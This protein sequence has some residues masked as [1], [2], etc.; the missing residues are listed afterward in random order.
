M[1]GLRTVTLAWLAVT[2]P[3]AS[4][5]PGLRAELAGYQA[6]LARVGDTTALR[7]RERALEPG[8]DSS[9]TGTIP[10]LH[11]GLTR[12]RL[13]QVGDGWSFGRATRDFSAAAAQRPAWPW[14]WYGRALAE[15]GR[16]EWLAA[17]P[18]NLG[19]RVGYGA[20]EEALRSARQALVAEPGFLP[21][22]TLLVDAA[23]VLR[24]TQAVRAEVRP[25]LAGA[26]AAGL[27]TPELVLALVRVAREELDDSLP[28]SVPLDILLRYLPATAE[29]GHALA[30]TGF[31]AGTPWADSLYYAAAAR[32]DASGVLA[33][34]EA[35]GA[36]ADD[37]ALA[38]FD[39]A[40]AEDRAGTLRQFWEARARRDLRDPAER[41]AEHYRRLAHATRHFALQ[42]NRRYYSPNNLYRSAQ[43]WYDDRGVVWIRFGAP[44]DR[45]IVPLFGLPPLETW[46]YRRADGDLLLHFQAG[47]Y[48]SGA[49]DF[50]G[51]IDDYRLVPT[52]FDAMYQRSTAWDLLLLSR[53]PLHPVYCRYPAWGP[54]GRAQLVAEE[55]R[56]VIGSTE[57]AV[58]GEGW[59]RRFAHGLQARMEAFAVGRRGE[60]TLVHLAYQVPVA[61]REG[62]PAGARLQSPVHLRVAVLGAD[63]AAVAWVDTTTIASLPPGRPGVLEA[64]GRA[65]FAVP[66]GR[67]RYRVELAV[68][69][70]TGQVFP[71]D[72][73]E[74]GDFDGARLALSDLVL[75]RPGIGAPWAPEAA[76][77]AYF[78]PRA[79]W[80]RG[81]TLALYHEVYGLAAGAPYLVRLTLRRGRRTALTAAWEGTASGPVT[82]LSRALSLAALRPGDYLLE[83]AVTAADGG[84]ATTR[85]RVTITE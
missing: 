78:T 63:G 11:R 40:P 59:E 57:V 50:G 64:F 25:A 80:A 39:A 24:D 2:A 1:G 22:L 58:S 60:R 55:Q 83:L 26:W 44:D 5:S 16:A 48:S 66:P 52:L 9:D 69:D 56:V 19:S 43:Q 70:S 12:I 53:C 73:L 62:V 29:A 75:G 71:T 23:V 14:P 49:L 67:W 74:V 30:W 65:A 6:D 3:L 20:L 82:R 77:T 34:R 15:Q 72:S 61:V 18:L 8:T 38:G 54:H 45:V 33:Y 76:D 17:D 81:D 42:L 35:L 68:G 46:H 31:Q 10:W 37:S 51:A 41:V 13:G 27:R 85:R 4:Q 7:A 79:R 36:I 32:D 21:A 28:P 47:G 84:Q